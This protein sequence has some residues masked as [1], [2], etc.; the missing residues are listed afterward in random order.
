M[1]LLESD[2]PEAAL[3]NHYTG[4]CREL[5]ITFYSSLPLNPTFNDIFTF[6]NFNTNY[7]RSFGNINAMRDD[8]LCESLVNTPRALLSTLP[9]LPRI[10]T[11]ALLT[12]PVVPSQPL[13]K[14]SQRAKSCPVPSDTLNLDSCTSEATQATPN[15]RTSQISPLLPSQLSTMAGPQ[16]SNQSP[17]SRPS[18]PTFLS[19]SYSSSNGAP[20]SLGDGG[21]LGLDIGQS[22]RPAASEVAVGGLNDQS[23]LLQVLSGV[24]DMQKEVSGSTC[25]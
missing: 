14:F 25:D 19:S 6:T 21:G 15:R 8:D 2:L 1:Q 18:N 9:D 16:D 12:P 20:S 3:W 23:L 7:R 24:Q 4:G 22:A 10:D 11:L 5:T 17:A 13:Y